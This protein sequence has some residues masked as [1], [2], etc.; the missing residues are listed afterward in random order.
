MIPGGC[1]IRAAGLDELPQLLNVLRGEMSLVGPRPCLPQEFERYENWHKARVYIPPG[2]TGYWQVNGKNKTSFKQMV[3]LDL[4]YAER[5][6]LGLDLAVMLATIPA[7][8]LQF[9][10]ARSRCIQDDLRNSNGLQAARPA[11][12]LNEASEPLNPSAEAA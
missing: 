11:P 5:M 10:E 6:S 3:E 7:L 1:W 4:L 8:I 2:L 9:V 12:P